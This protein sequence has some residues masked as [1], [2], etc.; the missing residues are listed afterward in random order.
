M[1]E[2]NWMNELSTY[3]VASIPTFQEEL[4]KVPLVPPFNIRVSITSI[5]PFFPPAYYIN[6]T[7]LKLCFSR[8]PIS[9]D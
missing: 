8:T 6:E 3:L 4:S 9:V 7:Q 1:N 5:D 2:Y